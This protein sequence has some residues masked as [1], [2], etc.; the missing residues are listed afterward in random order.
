M[1]AVA[2]K[3]NNTQV[4]PAEMMTW[5]CCVSAVDV[6]SL[7]TSTWGTQLRH[8]QLH[9]GELL[10]IVHDVESVDT[11]GSFADP[12]LRTIDEYHPCERRRGPELLQP[13]LAGQP[14]GC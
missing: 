9:C 8:G 13:V 12:L 2:T 4:L 7:F 5:S 11:D 10:R 14:L 6:L 3:T 1:S